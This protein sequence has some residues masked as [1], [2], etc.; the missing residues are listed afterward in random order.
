MPRFRLRTLLL[1]VVLIGSACGYGVHETSI[2]RARSDWLWR[3][4]KELPAGYLF[5]KADPA[6]AYGDK[7]QQPSPLRFWLGDESHD[8]IWV[9]DEDPTAV[10][11]QAVVLFPEADVRVIDQFLY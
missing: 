2:L 7:R 8:T 10:K 6:L 11:Q 3:H 1:T 5:F 4:R 9:T